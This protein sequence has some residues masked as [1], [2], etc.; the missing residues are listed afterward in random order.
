M[1]DTSPV[2]VNFD[3]GGSL[4]E[5]EICAL[6]AIVSNIR[7]P[8]IDVLLGDVDSDEKDFYENVWHKSQIIAIAAHER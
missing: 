5:L 8:G 3:G 4:T 1:E 2:V 7:Q 6:V